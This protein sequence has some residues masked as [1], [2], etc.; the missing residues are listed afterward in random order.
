MKTQEFD[1]LQAFERNRGWLKDEEQE[2]LRKACVAIAGIG[3]VG[4]YQAQALARLGVGKFKIVDPDVFE[5]TN[6]NR[7]IGAAMHTLGQPKVQV[8]RDMILSINP[9]VEVQ[10]LNQPLTSSNADSFLEDCDLVIDGIDFFEQDAK[11]LLFKKSYEKKIP[12]L[13]SCPLGF[14]ASLTVFSPVGMTY[15]N[16]FDLKEGM[17]DQEKRMALLFGLS[18]DPLCLSYLDKKSIDLEN[19]RAASVVPGLMLVGALSAAE[20]VKVITGKANVTYCPNI[21]QIDLLTQRVSKKNYPWGMKSPWQR[22]KKRMN[23]NLIASLK[24]KKQDKG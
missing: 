5:I 2:K 11:F 21:F 23:A 4:G 6:I 14:G 20:A 9:E 12:A 22:F 10:A 3:G 8:I 24:N 16:Y 15:E 17:S 18:P 1:Y 13:T 7:Q 19:H